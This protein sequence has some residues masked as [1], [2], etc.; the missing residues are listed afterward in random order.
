MT[1]SAYYCNYVIRHNR[2]PW[3]HLSECPFITETMLIENLDKPWSWL[4]LSRN[5]A[6]SARFIM[7]HPD[8]EWQYGYVLQNPNI[9]IPDIEY[10]RTRI[11]PIV[12]YVL[13]LN[14]NITWEYLISHIDIATLDDYAMGV[15]SR[16]PCVT[17]DIIQ[18]NIGMRWLWREVS[19]NPNITVQ[20]TRE[21]PHLGWC[22]TGICSNRNISPEYILKT[23]RQEDICMLGLSNNPNLTHHF[24]QRNKHLKWFNTYVENNPG[25][26][27]DYPRTI[28]SFK[29]PSR[30]AWAAGIISRWLKEISLCPYGKYGRGQINRSL[31]QHLPS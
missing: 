7:D 25:I 3:K 24:V 27:W 1:W 13:A 20:I 8:L 6:I 22:R 5:P 29:L 14:P 10:L 4:E 23:F 2:N 21:N 30:E 26:R 9:M 17:W 31:C 11:R 15:I 28:G 18:S 16:N 19:E 12:A